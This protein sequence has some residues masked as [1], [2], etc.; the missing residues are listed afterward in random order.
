M[1]PCHYRH[2]ADTMNMAIFLR[3]HHYI[4]TQLSAHK[5]I[6]AILVSWFLFSGLASLTALFMLYSTLIIRVY[7]SHY[8]AAVTTSAQLFRRRFT[9]F[10]EWFQKC[11]QPAAFMPRSAAFAQFSLFDIESFIFISFYNKILCAW[12]SLYQAFLSMTLM[13]YSATADILRGR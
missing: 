9:P 10:S 12:Y 7:I 8:F 4:A 2:Y 5:D 11:S 13:L 6:L 1:P 3:R